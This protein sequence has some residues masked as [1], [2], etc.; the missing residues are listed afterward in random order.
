MT[1]LVE[2]PLHPSL[3]VSYRERLLKYFSQA[4]L[5]LLLESFVWKPKFVMFAVA[6]AMTDTQHEGNAMATYRCRW[7]GSLAGKTAVAAE[8]WDRWAGW[9]HD[10][11]DDDDLGDVSVDSDLL[12]LLDAEDDV[13]FFDRMNAEEY[14]D[15]YRFGGSSSF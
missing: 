6:C 12:D 13:D 8:I 11:E 10:V 3:P 5:G 7:L 14:G 2:Q 9:L 15:D 1:S 4:Q